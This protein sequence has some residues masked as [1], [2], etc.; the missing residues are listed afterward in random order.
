MSKE[1]EILN[2]IEKEI[3]EW[4]QT[5]IDKIVEMNKRIPAAISKEEIIRHSYAIGSS[6]SFAIAKKVIVDKIDEK[7][8]KILEN[9][10][11]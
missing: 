6:D 1:I 11:S 3:S 9:E 5:A 7:K 8:R 4:L 2:E 10:N